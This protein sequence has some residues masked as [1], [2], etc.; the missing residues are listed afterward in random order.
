MKIGKILYIAALAILL[1]I[2]G[3]S[4]FYVGQYFLEGRQQQDEYD[5]LAA[6]VESIQNDPNYSAPGDDYANTYS[7]EG[8]E[9]GTPVLLPEYAPLYAM[10]NDM[11]GWLRIDGTKINYPVMQTPYAADYY[12]HRN[13]DREDS[14]R[15]CLYARESCDINLPSDNITIYG[16]NMADGSMF[17]GLS[18]YQ[19]EDFWAQ[20]SYITFDTLYEHH[21]YQIFAVFITT[22]S[23]GEGF[24]YH[25]FENA[26]DAAEFDAFVGTCLDLSFYDTGILPEYGDKLICL[27]TCEYTQVNGRLVVVAVMID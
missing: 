4:A 22:A 13:F 7:T 2:F 17:A 24:A 21:T 25:E 9:D 19:D 10:N 23:V 20:H 16:H 11:V 27:S 3:C 8:Y 14:A 15:G 26:A 6:I 1:V 5:E 12:L 18:K